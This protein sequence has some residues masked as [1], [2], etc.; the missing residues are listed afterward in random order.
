MS[1]DGK[2]PQATDDPVVEALLRLP[3][4]MWQLPP[5]GVACP[6]HR[7][8]VVLFAGGRKGGYAAWT[9]HGRIEFSVLA[10]F[11]TSLQAVAFRA[12]Y[13]RDYTERRHKP[14]PV[15][16]VWP[17]HV[18]LPLPR[19]LS[20]LGDL[21]YAVKV[22]VPVL[23]LELES[24][25]KELSEQ[26]QRAEASGGEASMQGIELDAKALL[27]EASSK[28]VER[29]RQER[30]SGGNKTSNA[31]PDGD[32][33]KEAVCAPDTVPSLGEPVGE[34]GGARR[35][36]QQQQQQ[37]QQLGPED[38]L[39][40]RSD[41]KLEKNVRISNGGAE[42]EHMDLKDYL[43]REMK[44]TD[45]LAAS[46]SDARHAGLRDR[47]AAGAA[48]QDLDDDWEPPRELRDPAQS[49][50]VAMLVA[51]TPDGKRRLKVPLLCVQG[52]FPGVEEAK[53]YAADFVA[54]S[55]QELPADFDILL[56][57]KRTSPYASA[58]DTQYPESCKGMNEYRQGKRESRRQIQQSKAECARKMA[59]DRL[60]AASS[61]SRGSSAA[62]VPPPRPPGPG[63]E[64]SG[65]SGAEGEEGGLRRAGRRE[66]KERKVAH[67]IGGPQ[68]PAADLAPVSLLPA[69]RPRRKRTDGPA[70]PRRARP[71]PATQGVDS[72]F[73]RPET[74]SA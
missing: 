1:T 69:P 13:S 23:Q 63:P 56:P 32:S 51:D 47:L 57:G 46:S 70:L 42:I 6:D 33:G 45:L 2:R 8:A 43:L 9:A 22:A 72:W 48:S 68:A 3:E 39:A 16:V 27:Q 30:R 60:L 66:A 35:Q 5:Q 31:G 19:K 64:G 50:A 65:A 18:W 59:A 28:M 49:A 29:D 73:G 58:E 10:S 41:G 26:R 37:P 44:E 24:R 14:A 71:N 21:S 4:I 62:A 55:R 36:Q 15:A 11:S 38:E 67:D 25:V 17:L 20:L 34:R 74:A 53:K 54:Q 52:V 40:A 7:W 12:A 61:I